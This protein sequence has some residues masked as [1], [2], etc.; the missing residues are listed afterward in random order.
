MKPNKPSPVRSRPSWAPSKSAF[1]SRLAASGPVA[2]LA[3][4]LSAGG[5]AAEEAQVAPRRSNPLRAGAVE[6][7]VEEQAV[8]AVAAAVV[9][10]GAARLASNRRSRRRERARPQ[11]P[12]DAEVPGR[13]SE[14]Q[15][16]P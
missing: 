7:P 12:G 2:P 11:D 3:A 6:G 9:A 8:G 13:V 1:P 14:S 4:P 5:K 10:H 15:S 16:R